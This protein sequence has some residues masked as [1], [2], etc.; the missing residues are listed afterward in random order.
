VYLL[1]LIVRLFSRIDWLDIFPEFWKEGQVTLAITFNIALLPVFSLI[2][3]FYE[4]ALG[5][6]TVLAFSDFRF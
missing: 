4:I 3:I 2:A 6:Y 5:M 1:H